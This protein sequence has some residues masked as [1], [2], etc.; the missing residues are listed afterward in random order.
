MGP[1]FVHQCIYKYVYAVGSTI[2]PHFDLCWVNNWSIFC[3]LTDLQYLVLFLFFILPWKNEMLKPAFQN[4]KTQS[5]VND[6]STSASTS[7]SQKLDQLLTL[8]WTTNR[9]NFLHSQIKTEQCPELV[10]TPIFRGLV[11]KHTYKQQKNKTQKH[12]NFYI[13]NLI[14]PFDLDHKGLPLYGPLF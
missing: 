1:E 2:G 5:Q 13:G 3:S 10:E 11:K 8:R 12:H 14:A 4:I 9:P 7:L 6:C